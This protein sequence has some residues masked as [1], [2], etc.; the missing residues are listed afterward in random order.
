L[1]GI[2]IKTGRQCSR[3]VIYNTR[4]STRVRGKRVEKGYIGQI[5]AF[6]IYHRELDRVY[7]IPVEK[8]AKGHG[9]LRLGKRG[10]MGVRPG[11]LYADDFLLKREAPSQ[12]LPQS[13]TTE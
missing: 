6:A 11:T 3:A 5:E 7:M 4:S 1:N 13:K 2:Q 8:A 10:G 9:W 12:T